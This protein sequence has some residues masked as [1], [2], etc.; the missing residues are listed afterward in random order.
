MFKVN[1][2]PGR[3]HVGP[4]FALEAI[5]VTLAARSEAQEA[6]GRQAWERFAEATL[7]HQ[8]EAGPMGQQ[9]AERTRRP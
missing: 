3:L 7:T 4:L 2:K 5:R 9:L 1:R 8:P 6:T